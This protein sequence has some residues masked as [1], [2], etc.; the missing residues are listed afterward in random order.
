[1]SKDYRMKMGWTNKSKFVQ[2]LKA[3]DIVRPNWEVIRLRNERLCN[4][5]QLVNGSQKYPSNVNV[6]EVINTTTEI[7][8]SN[9]ILTKLNNHGRA[10]ED[11][12]YT[13]LQG[14]LA[15]IIFQ[16]LMVKELSLDDLQRNGGDDLSDPASFKRTGA[17]DLVSH[18][19]KVL[20]DVQ[21]GFSSSG[22]Y[23]I[24]KHKVNE[25]VASDYDSYLFFANIVDG[26]YHIQNLK[27][28]E[29]AEFTPNPRWEGQLCYNVPTDD[30]KT[31]WDEE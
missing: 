20:I 8:K 21:A 3:S 17:A 31:F 23:D 11:V 2:Y 7:V 4:I 27:L 19:N 14:Y 22:G 9:G 28:L 1:M 29:E 26:T 10:I 16:P 15:E 30:F 24:K 12:Y 18:E 25:A 13:W 5:F 6:S